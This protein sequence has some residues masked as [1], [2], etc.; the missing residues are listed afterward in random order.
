V[1]YMNTDA[2]E[3]AAGSPLYT[4]HGT[5]VVPSIE[6]PEPFATLG[7]PTAAPVPFF[8]PANIPAAPAPTRW[9]PFRAK[10][11]LELASDPKPLPKPPLTTVQ[12]SLFGGGLALVLVYIVARVLGDRRGPGAWFPVLP[13]VCMVAGNVALIVGGVSDN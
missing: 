12:W 6:S 1:T 7:R 13:T 11:S 3:K 2:D 5:P 8:T 4:A 9:R 10:D